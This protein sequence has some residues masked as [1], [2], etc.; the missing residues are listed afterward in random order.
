MKNAYD[1][2]MFDLDGTL[3][4]TLADIAAAC[5]HAI[6]E[7]GR[8][9][10][11]L[12]KYR[13]LA[14]QGLRYLIEHALEGEGSEAEIEQG[15]EAFRSFYSVHYLDHTGPFDGMPEVL[16]ALAVSPIKTAVLSNKPD[17]ATR[18]VMAE[19][20]SQWSFDVIR[21]ALPDV[22]LKPDPTSALAVAAE[23][24]VVPE[25]WVYVGDTRVDMETAKAARF[26]AVGVL[27]GFRDEPELR[28]AG[29]DVIISDPRE[30]LSIVGLEVAT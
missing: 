21:G 29:A 20:F 5:N 16:D 3:A 15:M 1:A 24:G 22:P 9:P 2:I 17:P 8:P 10:I 14:G 11:E 7:L 28:E 6:G 30:L 19:V 13:Y 18:T 27:W 23:V 26:Y 12:P 25:R 4:D